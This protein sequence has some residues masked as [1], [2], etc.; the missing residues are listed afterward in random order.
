VLV[1]FS[2]FNKIWVFPTSFSKTTPQDK[3]PEKLFQQ[4]VSC[5]VVTE[6]ETDRLRL[7]TSRNFSKA[8]ENI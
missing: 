1:I 6:G 2:D 4:Q 5:F 3:V 7:L 8:T